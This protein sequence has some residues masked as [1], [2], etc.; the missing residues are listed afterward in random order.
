VNIICRENF[1]SILFADAEK[2]SITTRKQAEKLKRREIKDNFGR[3]V[4]VSVNAGD[5]NGVLMCLGV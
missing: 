5:M 4:D 2:N 1:Y 3:V